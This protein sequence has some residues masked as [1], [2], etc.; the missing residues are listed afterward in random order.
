M[1]IVEVSPLVP[2]NTRVSP[3]NPGAKVL[4]QSA[5]SLQLPPPKPFHV[6]VVEL[7]V[8]EML[9]E[10]LLPEVSMEIANRFVVTTALAAGTVIV[11]V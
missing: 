11:F 7:T 5:L 4:T 3:A 1:F 2:A 8:T 10:A 6:S 9:A